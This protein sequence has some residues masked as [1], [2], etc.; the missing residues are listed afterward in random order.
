MSWCGSELEAPNLCFGDNNLRRNAINEL[1]KNLE[2]PSP[3]WIGKSNVMSLT[4][5]C[6]S[7]CLADK[8]PDVELQIEVASIEAKYQR[9]FQ[10]LSKMKEEALVEANKKS[11]TEKKKLAAH[12]LGAF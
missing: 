6:T 1:T 4:S 12:Q 11:R 9:W 8:D 10:E 5:S 2:L 3:D 7:L